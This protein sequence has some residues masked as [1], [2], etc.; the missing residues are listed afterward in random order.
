AADAR[1][2][3]RLRQRAARLEK[4]TGTLL[5]RLGL[6][7]IPGTGAAPEPGVHDVVRTVPAGSPG[8]AG[9]VAEVLARGYRRNGEVLRRAQVVV[10]G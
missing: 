4:R 2:D 7:E 9:L 6:E 3:D 5:A 10:Y 8:Q 1:G